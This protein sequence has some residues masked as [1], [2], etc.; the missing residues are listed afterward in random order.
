MEF[1]T[2]YC[3]WSLNSRATR[4]LMIQMLQQSSPGPKKHSLCILVSVEQTCPLGQCSLPC[5]CQPLLVP[6]ARWWAPST[7]KMFGT[8][9][10]YR[11]PTNLGPWLTGKLYKQRHGG[12][13]IIA[14]EV[15]A[16]ND[17]VDIL[18]NCILWFGFSLHSPPV[19]C[20]GFSPNQ[21]NEVLST[22]YTHVNEHT[23]NK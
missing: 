23:K 18:T 4:D 20:L 9:V 14:A 3:F 1:L 2:F 5:I 10:S 8:E 22:S 7:H 13:N 11:L 21:Q 19:A 16:K 15:V 6:P 12:W 17:V